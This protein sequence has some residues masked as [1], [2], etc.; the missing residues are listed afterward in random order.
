L[1]NAFGKR[2]S[3]DL[4]AAESGVDDFGNALPGGFSPVRFS[5]RWESQKKKQGRHGMREGWR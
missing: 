2:F 5:E 1:E 4:E 3:L